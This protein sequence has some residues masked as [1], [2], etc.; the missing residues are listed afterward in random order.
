M[1]M[2]SKKTGSEADPVDGAG[3]DHRPKIFKILSGVDY[4]DVVLLFLEDFV[5]AFAR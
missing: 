4:A 1:R 3:C 5:E 2:T